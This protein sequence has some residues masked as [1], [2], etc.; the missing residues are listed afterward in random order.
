RMVSV[1]TRYQ[2]LGLQPSPKQLPQL[3]WA[4][5]ATQPTPLAASGHHRPSPAITAT[6]HH[7]LRHPP[8][9]TAMTATSAPVLA[10]TPPIA[11]TS[12][13]A[14]ATPITSNTRHPPG[15]HRDPHYASQS[16]ITDQPDLCMPCPAPAPFSLP[17][18]CVSPCFQYKTSTLH[19]MS[20]PHPALHSLQVSPQAPVLRPATEAQA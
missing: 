15:L 19:N 16:C 1:T 17:H 20:Q 9:I 3:P 10:I 11:A 6:S 12:V 18:H 5:T 8:A 14:L 7:H 13:P 4:Q 2:P